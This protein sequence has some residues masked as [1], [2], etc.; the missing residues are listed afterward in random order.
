MA[1]RAPWWF[2]TCGNCRFDLDG[3]G[4]TGHGTLYAGLDQVTGALETI[5]PEM[6]GG[7]IAREFLAARVV[8]ALAYDRPLQLADL[9]DPRATG[10]GVTNELTTMV[11]YTVPQAWATAFDDIGADGISYRTRFNIA[12]EATGVALFDIA[13]SHPDWP[14]L[15]AGRADADEMVDELTRRSITVADVPVL[16][17]M[18]LL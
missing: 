6:I 8:W 18:T 1:R 4:G 17:A 5:G 11:P 16:G 14:A 3:A 9:T 10:F 12:S 7:V 13:G 2:C 15:H